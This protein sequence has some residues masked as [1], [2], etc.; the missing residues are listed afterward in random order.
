M[1]IDTENLHHA[2][3]VLGSKNDTDIFIGS[4]FE[5]IDIKTNG[6]PDV[7]FWSD[8]KFGIDEARNLKAR[9]ESKAFGK[10]KI[11]I[12][13]S[14][15][16]TPE[17]QNALLKV[18]EEPTP[19]THFVILANRNNLLPTLLSR[20]SIINLHSSGSNTKEAEKFLKLNTGDRLQ[21]IKTKTAD[22]TFILS[23]FLDDLLLALR[24]K[25]NMAQNVKNTF[26]LSKFSKDPAVNSRLILEHLALSLPES[27]E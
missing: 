26:T 23:D 22:E 24:Q 9:A 16:I 8:E 13:N 10:K 3:L 15:Q 20:L 6:N 14:L 21:Y 19:N 18:F 4:F 5:K 27:I 17:A 1:E 7:V 12:I 2:Y 11:F 25:K